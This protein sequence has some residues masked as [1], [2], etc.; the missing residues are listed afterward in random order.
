MALPSDGEADSDTRSVT[1]QSS[2]LPLSVR[3]WLILA[4]LAMCGHIWFASDDSNEIFDTRRIDH[5]FAEPARETRLVDARKHHKRDGRASI[6]KKFIEEE[7]GEEEAVRDD[8]VDAENG[9][10]VDDDDDEEQQENPIRHRKD[11]EENEKDVD[12]KNGAE[13]YDD[14]DEEEQ[15]LE[16]GGDDVEIEALQPISFEKCCIPAAFKQSNNQTDVDCFG[17]CFTERA[18]DDMVYPFNSAEEKKLFPSVTLTKEGRN[19]RR[20][21]CMS[22]EKLAPP[23]EW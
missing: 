12:I 5:S 1:T 9:Y 14:K 2:R 17:T 3:K 21:E 23:V 10:E 16:G 20:R 11:D 13:V 4:W 18:C 8:E 7:D 15:E 19:K 6:E 22:P